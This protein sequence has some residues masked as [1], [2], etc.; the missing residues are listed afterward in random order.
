MKTDT[1]AAVIDTTNP[2]GG[3]YVTLKT[4]Y[5]DD[6]EQQASEF[7]G[8]LPRHEEGVYGLDVSVWCPACEDYH[9]PEA[10]C[11]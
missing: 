9:S 4:F 10:D 2:I 11:E 5:G 7:I 3:V 8:M 6:A 1:R